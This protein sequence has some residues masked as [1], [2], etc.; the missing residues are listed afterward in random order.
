MAAVDV[1]FI[2]KRFGFVTALDAVNL[3]VPEKSVFGVLGP[4]G[5][6]KTTLFS[7]IA[8]FI[9]PDIGKVSILGEEKR[10]A[11]LGRIGI[12][13]QDALFQADIPIIDQ[14]TY[15]LRLMGWSLQAA[16]AEVLRVM[17]IVGLDSILLREAETLS[18]GM[19]KRLALAQAFLASPEIIILDEPTSGLD[20]RSSKV[21]REKILELKGSAT[22]LVSSHNMTEMQQLCDHVAVLEKGRL[23]AVGPVDEVAGY[24]SSVTITLNR[25][26]DEQVLA[27]CRQREGVQEMVLQDSMT[28]QITFKPGLPPEDLDAIIHDVQQIILSG[29]VTVKSLNEDNRIERLYM[30]VTESETGE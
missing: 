4:N 5:A 8:G 2:T 11:L 13:P 29:G 16:E 23:V 1:S 24:A 25:E 10:E 21:I 26:P 18:H 3:S 30:N 15:F 22:I 12:L 6:G 7:V 9:R 27:E 14:L 17:K 20:W 28:Y 19:Y